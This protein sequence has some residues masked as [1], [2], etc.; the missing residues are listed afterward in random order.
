MSYV[1]LTAGS[2]VFLALYDLFKKISVRDKKDIYEI[3]FFYT[4]IAFLCSLFF[5][6]SAFSISLKYILFI[7]I[8][9]FLIS[10]SWFLTMKAMSKL[11]LGIVV[12]FSMLGTV[13]T[14]ILAWVFFGETIGVAQIGGILVILVGLFLI[15]RI[16]RKNDNEV[17]D[18]KYLWL[19]ALAAFLTSI[20]AILDKY[21]LDDIGRGS[22]LFW[23]FL[24]LAFIY[25]IICFIKNKKIVLNNFTNNL[26]VIGIGVSIFLSDLLYY[27]AVSIGDGNLSIISIIRKLSVFI[28]LVLA[29][30]FLKEKYF[31]KK[32]LVMLLMFVG[33][34]F[35]I[36]I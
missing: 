36:F 16:S 26:W 8:K 2:A 25:L 18:Y 35:I 29:S 3:L 11:D 1:F 22:V 27:S 14:T 9:S 21:L 19:L 33:L 17:N 12:P 34:S 30:I 7:L 32:L 6:N 5:I 20:S 23:F 4:L 13:S 31:V 28:G 10:L 24:F 15:S